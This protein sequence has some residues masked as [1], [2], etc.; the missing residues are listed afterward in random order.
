MLNA[1]LGMIWLFGIASQLS[2][3]R[4]VSLTVNMRNMKKTVKI[5]IKYKYCLEGENNASLLYTLTIFLLEH[6]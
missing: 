5:T 1:F 6:K 4:F 2:G 3:A